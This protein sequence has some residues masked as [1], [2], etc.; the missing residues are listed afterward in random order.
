MLYKGSLIIGWLILVKCIWIWWVCL[1]FN[2]ILSWYIVFFIIFEVK[3]CVI[4]CCLVG[5]ICCLFEWNLF[6]LIGILIVCGFKGKSVLIFV[7]YICVILLFFNMWSRIF[8]IKG[9]LVIIN[10]FIVFWFSWWI[11]L[12]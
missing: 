7:L 11:G 12:I 8:F 9:F 1:V 6:L 5:D 3:M 4:V 2:L 10:N